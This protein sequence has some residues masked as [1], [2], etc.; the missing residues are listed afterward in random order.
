MELTKSR[1]PRSASGRQSPDDYL[2]TMTNLPFAEVCLF[3]VFASW[4]MYIAS[5]LLTQQVIVFPS[6][7]N[8]KNKV[9]IVVFEVPPCWAHAPLG[10]LV[11]QTR[12]LSRQWLQL[13]VSV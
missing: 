1:Q 6:F 8:W 2:S 10:R 3:A 4:F 9:A 13:P 12:R 11:C 5:K 7:L